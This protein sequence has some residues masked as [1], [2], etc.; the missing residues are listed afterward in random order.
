M[1]PPVRSVL[2][3]ALALLGVGS[4]VALVQFDAHFALGVLLT[5]LATIA[6]LMLGVVAMQNVGKSNTTSSRVLA[7]PFVLKL[8]LLL[9]A[10]WILLTRFPPLSVVLG[11]T[12]LIASITVNAALGRL[13]P[14]V[15]GKA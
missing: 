12:T 14:G 1:T 15:P 11:A 9:G 8:P 3:T 4:V 7:V 5:G 13:L 10:G 6:S 2:Y